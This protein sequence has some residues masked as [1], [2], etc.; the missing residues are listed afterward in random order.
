[1][2]YR[3]QLILIILFAGIFLTLAYPTHADFRI[4][5][6]PPIF[7]IDANTPV[8]I[9]KDITV[10]N[11]GDD[12]A[13]L[14]IAWRMFEQGPYNNG[15]VQYIADKQI[16]QDKDI[17]QKI[18]LMDENDNPVT[19]ITLGPKQKKTFTIHIGLPKDEPGADYYFS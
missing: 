3:K 4:G 13:N 17:F 15:Q 16:Q 5:I 10:V 7:Q 12:T 8:A 9:R 11:A 18:Q 6:F 19:S 1:M 2:K 14:D